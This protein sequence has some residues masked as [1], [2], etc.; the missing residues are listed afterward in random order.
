VKIFVWVVLLVLALF[1]ALVLF[2]WG[3]YEA[4]VSVKKSSRIALVPL[5][6]DTTCVGFED[7]R[8]DKIL[9]LS[10]PE[11]NFRLR[12]LGLFL[13]VRYTQ[14]RRQIERFCRLSQMRV[15]NADI[16]TISSKIL[17]YHQ[18]TLVY[19]GAF[20]VDG[21]N[22][23]FALQDGEY[24]YTTAELTPEFHDLLLE[25]DVF[26]WPVVLVPARN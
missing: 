1:G 24:G 6:R 15:L 13:P 8:I 25:F 3:P 2:F 19:S 14:D 23:E 12:T 7:S 18:D 20:T 4:K 10:K 21:V 9:L 17:L 11:E 5:D 16:A 26:W 22:H